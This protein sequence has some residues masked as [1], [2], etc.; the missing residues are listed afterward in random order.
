MKKTVEDKKICGF[1]I[2]HDFTEFMKKG[3]LFVDIWTNLEV[4]ERLNNLRNQLP[5]PSQ[6]RFP[7]GI[8]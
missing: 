1:T 6:L 3:T 7:Y 8:F 5:S 4:I 2:T